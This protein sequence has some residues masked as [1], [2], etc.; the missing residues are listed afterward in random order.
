MAGDKAT[1]D[2]E[3][4]VNPARSRDCS[5]PK[6]DRPS[7]C[8]A[9]AVWYADRLDGG[10]VRVPYEQVTDHLSALADGLRV[11]VAPSPLDGHAASAL[12]GAAHALHVRPAE[13]VPL[14]DLT[15][16]PLSTGR[17]AGTGVLT[18]SDPA[19]RR[20]SCCLY[21]RPPTGSKCGDCGLA[22]GVPRR[23]PR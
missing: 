18:R 2:E 14:A 20:R 21:Y 23:G 12:A 19:F 4:G 8:P 7:G 9:R 5:G 10:P 11:K 17:L 22:G 6:T 13:R 3:A 16:A 1:A 15:T